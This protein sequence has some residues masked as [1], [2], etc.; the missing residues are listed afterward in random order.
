MGAENLEKVRITLNPDSGNPYSYDMYPV[1]NLGENQNKD[2]FS[3][4]PPG[5]PASDNILLGVGGMQADLPLNF[6]VWDDG[7]DRSNGTGDTSIVTV[8]EQ[9][10]YLRD[11]I[12]AAEFSATWELDHLTGNAFNGD[13]VFV[14]SVDITHLSNDSPKWKQATLRLRRGRSV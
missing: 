10:E 5:R 14:E 9:N 3:I 11:V 2:A 6:T 8:E 13:E 7:S 12:H 4:S 1:Q